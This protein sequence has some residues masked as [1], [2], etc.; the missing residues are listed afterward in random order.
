MHRLWRREFG[1]AYAVPSEIDALVDAGK[2]VDASNRFESSTRFQREIGGVTVSLWID[3]PDA[4]HRYS[5]VI[6][7][8]EPP[9]APP[10]LYFG[11][12]Q[13]DNLQTALTTVFNVYGRV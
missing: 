10:I 7:H 4:E 6:K 12:Y 9:I 13:G 3:H 1:E 8:D 11:L 5:V 2:L